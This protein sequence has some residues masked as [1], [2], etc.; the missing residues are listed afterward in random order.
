MGVIGTVGCTGGIVLD[1]TVRRQQSNHVVALTWSPADG[2]SVNILRNGA[3]LHGPTDDDGSAQDNLKHRTGT[4][5]YQVCETDT[6]D[7]S[8]EVTVTV[9]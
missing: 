1:A 7:C 8:N 2:G 6:G 5:T 9:R 3:V 4:F